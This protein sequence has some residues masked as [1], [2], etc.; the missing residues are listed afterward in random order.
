M[1]LLAMK[2]TAVDNFDFEHPGDRRSRE[3][4][5]SLTSPKGMAL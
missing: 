2:L 1:L 3:Q 5:R 4:R